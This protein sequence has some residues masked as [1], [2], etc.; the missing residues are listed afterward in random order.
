MMKNRILSSGISG[1]IVLAIAAAGA[2]GFPHQKTF[3]REVSIVNIP[4]SALDKDGL[5]VGGLRAGDFQVFE[6]GEP[7]E[8]EF[9]SETAKSEEVIL[10]IALLIDTS[11][12]VKDKL[13][14]EIETAAEFLREILRP[15]KDLALIMQFDSE[16]NLV[17][18]FTQNQA[19]LVDALKSLR[20]GG[21]TC[22]YDAVYLAAEEKLRTEAGRKVMVVISDGEDTSSLVSREEAIES[23]QKSDALI[24]GIGVRG[25]R[26]PGGFGDLERFAEQT[27]GAFFSPQAEFKEIQ[28][29][30]RSIGRDLRGQYSLAYVP[31]DK[32]KDGTFRKIE[33]RC[34]KRGVRIRARRGYYAPA[35]NR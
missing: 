34:H 32:R 4:F 18:D 7:Q 28:E 20:A 24:Y 33:I 2:I 9:F 31:T 25:R 8:I 11:G 12:S 27:G 29:T 5:P 13:R 14:H 6:N 35:G 15:E 16:V 23:A 21:D 26:S 10:T 30:F 22:L 17:Q 3:R 1:F 19:D